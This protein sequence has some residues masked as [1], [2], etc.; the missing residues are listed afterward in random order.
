MVALVDLTEVCMR[1]GGKVEPGETDE[2]ALL[3]ELK[4][5]LR[6]TGDVVIGDKVAAGKDG[7]LQVT[8][9]HVDIK[10]DLSPDESV[11]HFCA[12]IMSHAR[13][14]CPYLCLAHKSASFLF[15]SRSTM[16]EIPCFAAHLDFVFL[17]GA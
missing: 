11:S 16:Q 4:E 9:Y 10:G 7:P 13:I 5:E 15:N 12:P 17:S 8:T 3:R 14:P 1:T 2:A 6:V